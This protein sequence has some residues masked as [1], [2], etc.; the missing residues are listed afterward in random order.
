MA[1]AMEPSDSADMIAQ[2]EATQKAVKKAFNT[3]F[4][5]SLKFYEERDALLKLKPTLQR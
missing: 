1:N 4:E 3:L 2:V 5:I